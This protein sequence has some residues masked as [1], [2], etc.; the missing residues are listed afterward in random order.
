LV[1]FLNQRVYFFV[2]IPPQDIEA[3]Y[4]SHR[5]DFAGLPVEEAREIA[6]QRLVQE[7]GDARRDQFVEGLRDKATI[8]LNPLE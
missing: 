4:G 6:E 3:Y 8:H 2:I 7:R 5:E 1:D